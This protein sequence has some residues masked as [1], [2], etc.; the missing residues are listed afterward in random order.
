VDLLL[1]DTTSTYFERDDDEEADGGL[2]RFGHSKDHRPDLPQIVI[3]LAVTREGIPVRV[4][5]WPG[6]TS[7]AAVLPQVNDD[8]RGWRLG[9][10]VTIV[11]RGFSSKGEEHRLLHLGFDVGVHEDVHRPVR[12]IVVHARQARHGDVVAWP[13][14]R[15]RA[16][17]TGRSPGSPRGRT[18]PAPRQ[19]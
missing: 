1:F 13:T 16:S 19:W 6:N 15:P 17:S 10:V 2:R 7:D 11:D 14:R 4:W 3:R 12:L 5:T 8:L 18:A 9:R